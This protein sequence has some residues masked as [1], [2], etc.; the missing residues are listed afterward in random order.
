MQRLALLAILVGCGSKEAPPPKPPGPGD[1]Q[2]FVLDPAD[3]DP[4]HQTVTHLRQRV[5]AGGIESESVM[6]TGK[7]AGAHRLKL[8]PVGDHLEDAASGSSITARLL[9]ADGSHWMLSFRPP[10]G[11]G[12]MNVAFDEDSTIVDGILTV[13]SMIVG[14]P[15]KTVIRYVPASCDVVVAEL[16]KYPS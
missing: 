12:A 2:C 16:A 10:A 15:K 3:T 11:S 1:W 14:D 8:V 9:A 5:V 7:G 4:A 6:F 13:T